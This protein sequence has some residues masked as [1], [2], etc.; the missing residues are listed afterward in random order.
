MNT[1]SHTETRMQVR[2]QELKAHAAIREDH[3]FWERTVLLEHKNGSVGL[4]RNSF[5]LQDLPWVV[6]L[7]QDGS[8]QVVHTDDLDEYKQ[9]APIK[10][11][12]E[13]LSE[14]TP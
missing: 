10:D 4:F 11:G 1:D 9:F 7:S 14:Y 2:N 13:V 12:L 6:V 8:V 5:L 3:P